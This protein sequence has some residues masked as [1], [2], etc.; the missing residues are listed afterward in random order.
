MRDSTTERPHPD[1]P[2]QPD[3]SEIERRVLD[4]WRRDGTFEWSGTRR[5]E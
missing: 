5:R 2:Q 4:G 3:F 1:V